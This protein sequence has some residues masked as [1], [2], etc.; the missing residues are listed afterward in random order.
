MLVLSEK[1]YGELVNLSN[2]INEQGE[3]AITRT[4]RVA[5]PAFIEGETL[6]N[7][8]RRLVVYVSDKKNQVDLKNDIH[9]LKI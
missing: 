8:L 7:L 3:K 6:T 2:I 1:K 9:Y 4:K 5:G